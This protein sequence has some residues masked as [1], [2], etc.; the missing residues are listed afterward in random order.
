MKSLSRRQLLGGLAAAGI[1]GGLN[2]KPA[3]ASDYGI[4]RQ[5][6]KDDIFAGGPVLVLT[7]ATVSDSTSDAADAY[8]GIAKTGIDTFIDSLESDDMYVDNLVDLDFEP[9]GDF[10]A[11]L[12]NGADRVGWSFEIDT[13][14]VLLTGYM[15][16]AQ[17]S[18]CVHVWCG[19]GLSG[20]ERP[21][22]R[23]VDRH[24]KFDAIDRSDLGDI[25]PDESDLAGYT[26]T[27]DEIERI[28]DSG[29]WF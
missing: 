24:M 1:A 12:D 27:E 21:F 15:V 29:G 8:R 4:S 6:E 25:V 26:M 22:F 23:I 10:D 16:L 7:M 9:G 28:D 2:L 20:V 13:D 11:I 3:A 5:F 17:K 19:I 18:R 14:G